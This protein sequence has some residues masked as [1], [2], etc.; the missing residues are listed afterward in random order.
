MYRALLPFLMLITATFGVQ[1][2]SPAGHFQQRLLE[3]QR[4]GSCADLPVFGV[5]IHRRRN[6]DDINVRLTSE[7]GAHIVRLDVPWIDLER[8]GQYDFNPIDNLIN[9]LRRSG[10]SIDLALAYGHP[11]HS[12]GRAE[13]GFP[14]PP[15]TTEQ[16]AAYGRFAQAVARRYRGPDIVY[17]IWNEPNLALFWPPVPDVKAYGELLSQAAR[18]IREVDPTAKIIPGGLANE[19]NPPAF[20]RALVESGSLRELDGITFHPYRREGPENSLYDIAEFE[21]SAA[22]RGDRPLWL[23]EW[24]YSESWFSKL[25]PERSRERVSVVTAR[26]MLTAALA[27]AKA[28]LVYDLIDDGT[29][30]NDQESNFGLYDYNFKPKAAAAAFRIMAGLMSSCSKYRFNADPVNNTVTATFY[31]AGAASYVVWTYAPGPAR[32]ICLA[33]PGR[34]PIDLKS[35]SGDHLPIESCA[36]ASQVRLKLSDTS[37]PTILLTEGASPK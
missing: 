34:E 10:I 33:I 32:E 19:N 18:A 27:K 14:L 28:A 16:Q 8:N 23:N 3:L 9:E 13:N 35:V 2:V 12:D 1:A 4:E 20:L 6:P 36:S 7:M 26:L 30:P 11:D 17:E 29:D 25:G 24:G 21:S 15:Y 5:N 37:G 31:S 22:S